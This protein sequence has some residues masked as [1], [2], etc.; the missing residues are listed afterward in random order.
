MPKIVDVVQR[1]EQLGEAAARVIAR[2]GIDG[3][4]L[5]EVASEAGWTTGALSHYFANKRELLAFT[6]QGSLD[7]RRVQLAERDAMEPGEALRATLFGSLPTSPDARLHWTVTLAFAGQS[8]ADAELASIQR[9]AYL[10]VRSTI[11]RLLEADGWSMGDAPFE[12]ER[13]LAAVNGIA[14]QAFFA[15][16][17][18]D[19]TRQSQALIA[20]IEAR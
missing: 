19:E 14:L 5:R 7:R 9:E 4:S 11:I 17:L 16:D 1:R 3:A 2:S 15:P 12:A 13:L 10:H 20:A 6:L 8:S 18:W